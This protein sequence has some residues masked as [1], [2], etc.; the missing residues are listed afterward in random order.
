MPSSGRYLWDWYFDLATSLR[1]VRDGICEP[2]PASEY[3]AWKRATGEIVYTQEYA[4]LRAMD[5]AYCDEMNKE[6]A[7]YRAR[8]KE[9][10]EANTP[11][12]KGR[13]S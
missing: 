1:R 4:I 13:R 7:D 12:P 11:K 9:L 8:Q 6:L 10:A 5:I 2:I 3:L